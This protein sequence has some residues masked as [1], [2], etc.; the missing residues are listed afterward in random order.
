MNS[1]DIMKITIEKK[2]EIAIEMLEH[3]YLTDPRPFCV[4]YS[5]GKDSSVIVYLTI[6]MLQKLQEKKC[7]S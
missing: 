3:Y 6:K 4:A 7:W 5:G 1:R 2:E